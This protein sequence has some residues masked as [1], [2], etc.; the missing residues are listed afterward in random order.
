MKT[1]SAA[2]SI[3]TAAK[4]SLADR[5]EGATRKV[6]VQRVATGAAREATAR[7]AHD[8]GLPFNGPEELHH[9]HQLIAELAV[10]LAEAD[11]H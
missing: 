8:A 5:G 11:P 1:D 7:A 9:A 2:D 6:T 10:R 4:L 3:V